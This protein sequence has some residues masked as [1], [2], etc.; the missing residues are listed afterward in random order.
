MMQRTQSDVRPN[1][2]TIERVGH[3][4][5][6]WIVPENTV[7]CL[8][9]STASTTDEQHSSNEEPAT[10]YEYDLYETITEWYDGIEEDVKADPLSWCQS[11]PTQDK[12]IAQ[13]EADMLDLCE[14]MADFY[15]AFEL[16]AG[17][18]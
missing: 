4:A 17:G 10:Y 16:T 11:R 2:V 1:V 9:S 13:V 6:V 8:T 18:E 3:T 15:E 14:A 7:S 5:I 12:R